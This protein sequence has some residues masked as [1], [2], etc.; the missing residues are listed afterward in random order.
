[1]QFGGAVANGS[2]V[3]GP[4]GQLMPNVTSSITAPQQQ[5]PPQSQPPQQAPQQP[6]QQPPNQPP[7]NFMPQQPPQ[8]PQPSQQQRFLQ[9]QPS[10]PNAMV[11]PTNGNVPPNA[12]FKP[13]VRHNLPSNDTNEFAK[14]NQ[15]KPFGL[16]FTF[17]LLIFICIH[18]Y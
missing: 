9:S 13:S 8:Q 3:P 10:M 17:M 18:F 6:Q 4:G 15:M 1:M 7:G 14:Q 16:C 2:F 11:Q 5:P 12:Q